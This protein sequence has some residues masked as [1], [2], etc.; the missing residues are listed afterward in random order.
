MEALVRSDAA[1]AAAYNMRRA[2]ESV[3]CGGRGKA[4]KRQKSEFNEDKQNGENS[5]TAEDSEDDLFGE[6]FG[7]ECEKT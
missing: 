6:G 3:W 7:F 1:F 5:H 4:Q 2:R